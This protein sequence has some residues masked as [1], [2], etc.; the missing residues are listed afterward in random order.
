MVYGDSNASIDVHEDY[1]VP[2]CMNTRL[3]TIKNL[4]EEKNISI[5]LNNSSIFLKFK[6]LDLY[7][8]N[9]NLVNNFIKQIILQTYRSIAKSITYKFGSVYSY[10]DIFT[11]R[12]SRKPMTLVMG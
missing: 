8:S 1:I 2:T 12:G 9:F 10:I 7:C 11:D 5:D 6:Q 4:S 3:L